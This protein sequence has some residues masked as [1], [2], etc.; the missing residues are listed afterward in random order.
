VRRQLLEAPAANLQ[1]PPMFCDGITVWDFSN[2][3]HNIFI[4][5]RAFT[6]LCHSCL[7]PVSL[8]PPTD[9]AQESRSRRSSLRVVGTLFEI[10]I[11]CLMIDVFHIAHN[12]T[13]TG[14][15][16]SHSIF[17]EARC[18][19]VSEVSGGKCPSPSGVFLCNKVTHQA[20]K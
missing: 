7:G 9:A 13:P 19:C 20:C 17:T 8:T 18:T 12:T 11:A 6:V 16:S 15:S 2:N 4:E 3:V 10:R 5:L 14:I 1:M